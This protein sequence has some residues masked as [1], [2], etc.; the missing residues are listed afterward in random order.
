VLRYLGGL[1]G[2][3][4]S[5]VATTL[6]VA[7]QWCAWWSASTQLPVPSPTALKRACP[8]A[9]A[10][11][12]R[13][14]RVDASVIGEI[15]RLVSAHLTPPVAWVLPLL[16]LTGIR[17]PDVCRIRRDDVNFTDRTVQLNT[18]IVEIDDAAIL[19]LQRAVD[20]ARSGNAWLFPSVQDAHRHV[21]GSAVRMAMERL[22]PHLPPSSIDI[23]LHHLRCGFAR[24]Q[25]R[26]GWPVHRLSTHL[27]L[28]TERA[29]TEMI[30]RAR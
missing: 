21:S 8:E 30:E 10:P 28:R 11:R 15:D 29:V 23:T 6:S 18:H 24:K 4:P 1:R 26:A 2:K 9:S 25:R 19:I 16:W 5:T 14:T 3:A 7:H 20:H 12:V 17:M 13:R 22:R 27:G